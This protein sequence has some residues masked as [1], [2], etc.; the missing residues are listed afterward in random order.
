MT[1]PD[2]THIFAVVDRS[3]SMAG[4]ST[5][6]ETALKTLINEQ[7]KLPGKLTV[8]VAEFDNSYDMVVDFSD[9]PNC[10]DDWTLIPRGTTALHDAIGKTVVSVGERL[11]AMSE[12]ERPGKVIGI[13]VTDGME[14]ASQ[15]WNGSR[16]RDLVEQQ[17][18][19]YGWEFI[20]TAANQD[21]V[22]VG[23]SMGMRSNMN[24]AGTA[25]GTRS[26][27]AAMNSSISSYRGGTTATV[28][29][30]VDADAD[31]APVT[32]EPTVD[33]NT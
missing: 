9:N 18:N 3:G 22:M 19:Q 28:Q 7:F 13:I 26:A 31:D 27:Y 29:V 4:L 11:A 20:Y 23:S 17:T 5:E 33:S 30:P 8:T 15:D 1:N 14:N 12:D 10:L 6:S 24:Y 21:A 2:Y 16:I 32:N 25:K